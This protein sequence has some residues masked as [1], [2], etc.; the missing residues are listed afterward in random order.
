[1]RGH[2][3]GPL[4]DCGR[5]RSVSESRTYF[6]HAF[7]QRNADR[8]LVHRYLDES[9]IRLW[10]KM[11]QRVEDEAE[12]ASRYKR[13]AE[14]ALHRDALWRDPGLQLALDWKKKEQ[15]T[16]AWA[17]HYA[18][19]DTTFARAMD[20]LERS[21]VERETVKWNRRY[22]A[23]VFIVL[24]IASFVSAIYA[25]HQRKE[26]FARQLG[27]Q[28][29]LNAEQEPERSALLAAESLKIFPTEETNYALRQVMELLAKPVWISK[30]DGQVFATSFSPNGPYLVTGSEDKTARVF[31]VET[32][33]EISR[34]THDGTVDT[35]AFSPDGHYVATGS[36]DKTARVFEATSGKEL[37]RLVHDGTVDMVVFSP[38]GRYVAT[39]SWDR[40]AR[41]FE[42]LGGREVL[43]VMHGG[44]VDA[45]AFSPKGEYFASGSWDGAARVFA[46]ATRK[47]VSRLTFGDTVDVGSIQSRRYAGRG[48]QLGRERT[49]IPGLRW[50]PSEKFPTPISGTSTSI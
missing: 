9:L 3:S 25:N 16:E 34:L 5:N 35:V 31:E 7:G 13:L 43:R 32:G 14:A 40:T 17:S 12:S 1:M 33:K 38:D 18:P 48:G 22:A 50:T 29:V 2:R 47:E 41:V 28:A 21:R 24:G 27:Y 11:R 10:G 8:R 30:Q 19:G 23:A 15:P 45:V 26:A 44:I 6:P 20:F 4:S 46:M 37:S 42:A 49:T 36:W 39:A